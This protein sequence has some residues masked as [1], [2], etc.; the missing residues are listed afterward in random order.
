MRC[1]F[2][3]LGIWPFIII[4]SHF[5]LFHHADLLFGPKNLFPFYIFFIR[6]NFLCNLIIFKL[7]HKFFWTE[8]LLIWGLQW[9]PW[10][11]PIETSWWARYSMGRFLNIFHFLCL[12]YYVIFG[13]FVWVGNKKR[14]VWWNSMEFET[15]KIIDK[16]CPKI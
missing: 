12:Q 9:F 14:K 8:R 2:W 1:L 4:L 15:I 7:N 13:S 16:H 11:L 3:K 6:V 5:I 10:Y